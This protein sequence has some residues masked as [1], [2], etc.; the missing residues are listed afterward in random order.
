MTAEGT[1]ATTAP[2]PVPVHGRVLDALGLA[3]FLGGAAIFAWAWA[4][5]RRVQSYVPPPEAE[6]AA[7]ALADSYWRLQKIGGWV[8]A[9]GLAVFVV[10]WWVAGRGRD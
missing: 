4:G 10:A 8:M 1:R 9:A 2:A 3:I 7:V 6:G 5:F